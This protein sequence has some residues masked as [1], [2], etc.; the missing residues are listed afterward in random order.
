[1]DTIS[2][3]WQFNKTISIPAWTSVNVNFTN[4]GGDLCDGF[5]CHVSEGES[6]PDGMRATGSSTHPSYSFT[7]NYWELSDGENSNYRVIDFGT[8]PQ[9]VSEEFYEWFTANANPYKYDIVGTWVFNDI[10]DLSTEFEFG[11]LGGETIGVAGNPLTDTKTRNVCRILISDMP[12]ADVAT[13]ESALLMYSWTGDGTTRACSD[14]GVMV[15]YVE[16][17]GI[18]FNY[19]TFN[20]YAAQIADEAFMT[21]LKANATKQT[22]EEQPTTPTKK[23]TR[24]HRLDIVASSGGKCFRE[25]YKNNGMV[26]WWILNDTLTPYTGEEI[27]FESTYEKTFICNDLTNDGYFGFGKYAYLG[28]PAGALILSSVKPYNKVLYGATSEWNVFNSNSITHT[29]NNIVNVNYVSTVT[30][31]DDL[32]ESAKRIW[33]LP[34]ALK[35]PNIEILHEWLNANATK[36]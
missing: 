32:W 33:I 18:N 8:T 7:F 22:V 13:Y 4:F 10:I 28:N 9:T 36:L 14:E 30:P 26:G 23:F 19:I 5:Y 24:L 35:I 16:A 6:T 29:F 11:E 34:W 31:S 3:K 20:E 12:Y 25:L 1:M 21:W 27:V 15:G 17:Y 2:G